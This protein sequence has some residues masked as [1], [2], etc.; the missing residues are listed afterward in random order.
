M[1]LLLRFSL[2]RYLLEFKGLQ[3][4]ENPTAQRNAAKTD[5]EFPQIVEHKFQKFSSPKIYRE[6]FVIFPLTQSIHYDC[7]CS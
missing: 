1:P 3:E 6:L 5:I 2:S 4:E 7:D